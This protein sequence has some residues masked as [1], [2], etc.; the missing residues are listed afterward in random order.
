[1]HPQERLDVDH[2]SGLQV[3]EIGPHSVGEPE[4]TGVRRPVRPRAVLKIEAVRFRC[5]SGDSRLQKDVRPW[6]RNEAE[7]GDERP[8]ED[9]RLATWQCSHDLDPSRNALL[10][11]A[12]SMKKVE[13]SSG[14]LL[15]TGFRPHGIAQR[16]FFER[17]NHAVA[18]L[19]F[20]ARRARGNLP[21]LPSR[22]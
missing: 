9:P 5:D 22:E 3:G 11:S 21:V 14:E 16:H 12:P 8:G 10:E 6:L 4:Q 2:V 13:Q 15:G 20:D 18:R 7:Y 19:L 1:M 17:E